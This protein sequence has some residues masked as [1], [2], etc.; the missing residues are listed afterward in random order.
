MTMPRDEAVRTIEHAAAVLAGDGEPTIAAN[1]IAA[2][3][4]LASDTGERGVVDVVKVLTDYRNG[5]LELPSKAFGSAI[6]IAIAA[7]R[8]QPAGGGESLS[9][10]QGQ[11]FVMVPQDPTPEMIEAG[12][13]FGT[14]PNKACIIYQSMVNAAPAQPDGVGC[15]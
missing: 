4:A 15:D 3:S 2:L 8:A 10:A 13:L 11:G 7:L 14:S 12:I 9:V 6:D 1:L 5:E